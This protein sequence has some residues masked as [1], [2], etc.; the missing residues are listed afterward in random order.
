MGGENIKPS[1]FKAGEEATSTSQGYQPKKVSTIRKTVNSI[2][3]KLESV[4]R[5]FEKFESRKSI[6]KV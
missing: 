5:K 4:D 6:V 1:E 2:R 3:N